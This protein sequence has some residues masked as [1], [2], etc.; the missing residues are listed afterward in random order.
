MGIFSTKV[1]TKYLKEDLPKN[2]EGEVMAATFLSTPKYPCL[3]VLIDSVE[4]QVHAVSGAVTSKE[5]T[6]YIAKFSGNLFHTKNKALM[7]MMLN[8]SHFN[9]GIM[10]FSIDHHD[11]TGIW[12]HFGVVEVEE[13]KT[14]VPKK[15]FTVNMNDIAKKI[16]EKAPPPEKTEVLVGL[17]E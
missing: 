10:N 11:P 14:F 2:A 16:K 3:R 15:T 17:A 1:P 7:E 5:N 13:I 6:G 12:R 8:H 4:E 9:Q